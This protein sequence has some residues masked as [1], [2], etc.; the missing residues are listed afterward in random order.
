MT[1]FPS[2]HSPQSHHED[3][4]HPVGR[5]LQLSTAAASLGRA[6]D[7]EA[8]AAR[9]IKGFRGSML[10]TTS[11]SKFVFS[12]AE[13]ILLIITEADLRVRQPPRDF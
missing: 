3:Q 9:A 12:K 1:S 5:D 7:P 13:N 2:L 4:V 6:T 11:L 10:Y 8:A